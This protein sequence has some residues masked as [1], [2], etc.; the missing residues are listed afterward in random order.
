MKSLTLL[1]IILLTINGIVHAREKSGVLNINPQLSFFQ[2][3]YSDNSFV[4][5]NP[6]GEILYE[7]GLNNRFSLSTGVSYSYSTRKHSV[8]IKSHFKRVAHEMFFPFI[9]KF[10]LNNQ[11]FTESGIYPGWLI[12]GLALYMNNSNIK[13]WQDNTEYTS[14]NSSPRFS[15]DL[16]FGAGINIIKNEKRE[17]YFIP[18]VKYKI[19]DHW[20]EEIRKRTSFGL[21]I[22]IPIYI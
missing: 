2:D 3:K 5:V 19:N 17:I 13:N 1:V 14:Y 18:F 8:G 9:V 11:I 20:M 6:G 10:K 15:A 22:N 7:Y 12:K 16:Y 4:P 21:K